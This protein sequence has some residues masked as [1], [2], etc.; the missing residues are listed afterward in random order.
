MFYTDRVPTTAVLWIEP[1]LN[2]LNPPLATFTPQFSVTERSV[3]EVKEQSPNHAIEEGNP[4]S[5]KETVTK[6]APS[7]S[8]NQN[9]EHIS[10]RFW[11]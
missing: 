10:G 2:K 4:V 7:L 8:E 3:P 6:I 1:F 5:E 9:K 11:L